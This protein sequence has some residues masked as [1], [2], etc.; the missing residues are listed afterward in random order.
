[1]SPINGN[2]VTKIQKNLEPLQ[3][4]RNHHSKTE[5]STIGEKKTYLF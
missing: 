2:D 1:M 3:M 4:K 5:L